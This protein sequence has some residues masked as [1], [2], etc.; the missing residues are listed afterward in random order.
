MIC[1]IAEAAAGSI[2]CRNHGGSD[3]PWT[4]ERC[5]QALVTGVQKTTFVDKKYFA[6]IEVMQTSQPIFSAINTH[7][8][9]MGDEQ[10]L[11][12]GSV[13]NSLLPDGRGT[14]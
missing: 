2:V 8:P 6:R 7:H 4:L 13:N 5:P 3:A 11:E 14:A 9:P 12:L 10:P 1:T